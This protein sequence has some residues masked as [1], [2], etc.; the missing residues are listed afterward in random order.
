M[1]SACSACT[2]ERSKIRTPRPS[3]RSRSPNPSRAGWT[4]APERV[5]TPLRNTGESQTARVSSGVSATTC[6]PSTAPALAPSWAGAQETTRCGASR[7]HASTS[8]ALHHATTMSTVSSDASHSSIARR[9]PYCSVISGRLSHSEERK[10][11]LRPL[12]PVPHCADSRITTR[13][14]GSRSSTSHAVHIPV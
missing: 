9:S 1:R 12:G 4:I 14:L 10:P 2:R 8:C 6:S 13:A 3:S 11:P 7:T 5:A